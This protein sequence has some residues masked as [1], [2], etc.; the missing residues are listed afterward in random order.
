MKLISTFGIEFTY[1]LPDIYA[2]DFDRERGI[3]GQ[4]SFPF[5]RELDK[6]NKKLGYKSSFTYAH[7]DCAALE[8]GSPVFSTLNQITSYYEALTK[9]AKKFGF[10]THRQTS[11]SGGGHIHV[12]LPALSCNDRIKILTNA[13]RDIYNRPYLNYL[14][15]D[16][17]D[18]ETSGCF[19][20]FLT[21]KNE[22]WVREGPDDMALSL[23][24]VLKNIL[25]PEV[26][27]FETTILNLRKAYDTYVIKKR[28]DYT[29]N[30]VEDFAD[31]IFYKMRFNDCMIRYNREYN[32]IEFRIFDMAKD[33][34]QLQL[35]VRFANAYMNKIFKMDNLAPVN[36]GTSYAANR[37]FL[38]SYKDVNKGIAEF[39]ELLIELKL[40]PKDYKQFHKNYKDRIRLGY[41]LN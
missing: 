26:N 1:V 14:F 30:I 4:I 35:M 20:E 39:N 34:E 24:N 38:N 37:K 21:T 6:L 16:P 5:N 8:I 12:K 19:T 33:A 23:Y 2:H 3:I 13:M 10:Q 9:L 25:N 41:R 27:D 7:E 40:D 18:Q 29:Y 32:T 28:Q 31:T 17:C 36:H 15:N 22:D 11:S